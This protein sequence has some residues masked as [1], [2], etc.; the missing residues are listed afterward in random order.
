VAIFALIL[1]IVALIGVGAVYFLGK[2]N[3]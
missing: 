1:S 3:A 2:Q